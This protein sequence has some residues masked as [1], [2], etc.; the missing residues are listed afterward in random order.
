M[1]NGLKLL[2]TTALLGTLNCVWAEPKIVA[3]F[4]FVGMAMVLF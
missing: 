2:V 3:S 1:Q 4:A